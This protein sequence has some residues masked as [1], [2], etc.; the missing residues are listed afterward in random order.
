[1]PVI[2]PQISGDIGTLTGNGVALA[3]NGGSRAGDSG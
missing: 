2:G 3:R 1:M